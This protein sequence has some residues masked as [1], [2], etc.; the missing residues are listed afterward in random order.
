MSVQ[1]D[2]EKDKNVPPEV[3]GWNWG[4]F[5]FTWIWGICNGTLISLLSLI[6][7]VHFVMMFVLG[8]KG[9]EWAWRNKEWPSVEQFHSTQRKWAVA[10]I[11]IWL[12]GLVLLI[13][14]PIGLLGWGVSTEMPEI[15]GM[16][17]DFDPHHKYCNYALEEAERDSRCTGELGAP[18]SF[19]GRAELARDRY[20]HT[21][22]SIPVR[23]PRGEGMLFL[24]T[25]KEGNNEAVLE[26]AEMELQGLKRFK[27]ETSAERQR[28]QAAQRRVVQLVEAARARSTFEKREPSGKEEAEEFYSEQISRLKETPE[29]KESL[30]SPITSKV[31]SAKIYAQGPMGEAEFKVLLQGRGKSAVLTIKGLRTM[32]RWV[33]AGAQAQFPDGEINFPAGES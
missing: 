18:L 2:F 3:R 20:G 23:G 22:V 16:I 7:G 19:R 31:E 24:R 10:G 26:R 21:E 4:A 12:I 30:G 1:L 15:R 6:P 13:L 11:V 28:L 17:S 14:I 25:H 5:F 9:N 32:G 27:I 33:F 29:L 8:Y